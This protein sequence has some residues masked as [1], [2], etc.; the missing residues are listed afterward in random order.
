MVI[1]ATTFAQA[2]RGVADVF[3]YGAPPPRAAAGHG[4]RVFYCRPGQELGLHFSGA[5]EK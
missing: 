3:W 2:A 1:A 5:R 4:R